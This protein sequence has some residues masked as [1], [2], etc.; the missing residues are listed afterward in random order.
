MRELNPE[1][2]TK[3]MALINGAPY[4]QLL[5]MEVRELKPGYSLVAMN[6]TQEKLHNPFGTVHG[7]VYT[8]GIDTA[9]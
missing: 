3:L 5:S 4:F 2:I 8:S 9:A 7:G 6:V 1:H